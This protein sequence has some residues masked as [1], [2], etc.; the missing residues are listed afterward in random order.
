MGVT[1]VKRVVAHMIDLALRSC[2]GIDSRARS[3]RLDGGGRAIRSA[4][5]EAGVLKKEIARRRAVPGK[6]L[7]D[8][9]AH[10]SV[11]R[12]VIVVEI[13]HRVAAAQAAAK[14]SRTAGAR[15]SGA[16][17]RQEVGR[18][19]GAADIVVAGDDV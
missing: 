13:G 14:W 17:V 16:A 9:Y 11:E 2:A 18:G 1:V 3:Q 5:V 6:E 12:E 8:I 19:A 10:G 7:L 15:S 4:G